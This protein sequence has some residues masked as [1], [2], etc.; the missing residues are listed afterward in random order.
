[1]PTVYTALVI[2]GSGKA[3][4]PQP[5]KKPVWGPRFQENNRLLRDRRN[6]ALCIRTEQCVEAGLQLSTG[7]F[8]TSGWRSGWLSICHFPEQYADFRDRVYASEPRFGGSNEL[9]NSSRV[10]A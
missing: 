1:M 4:L 2:L 5:S 3:N 9:A 7:T 6:P 8:R 10:P